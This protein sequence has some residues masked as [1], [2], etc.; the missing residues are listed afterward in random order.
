M[1]AE[2]SALELHRP[3]VSVRVKGQD[4]MPT[5]RGGTEKRRLTLTA[6]KRAWKSTDSGTVMAQAIG[7]KGK[8]KGLQESTPPHA[9]GDS[10]DRP[11]RNPPQPDQSKANVI[12]RA[13]EEDIVLGRCHPR[14]RLIEH[15]LCD[16][17]KTH[18]GDVRQALYELEKKGI[19]LRIPNRGAM[20][21]DLAP[22]EVRQIYA[23]REEL[24]IMAVRTIPFPVAQAD[25]DKLD[26]LQREHSAAVDAGD[27]LTVFY[28]NLGFHRTVFELCQNP[29]LS[30]TIDQLAQRVYGIRSYANAFPEA[31]ERVRRDHREII[32]AMRLGRRDELIALTHRHL[33]PSPDAYIR[34]YERR[35]GES[36]ES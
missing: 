27:M 16:R 26:A 13:L 11:Q 1:A 2:C 7:K 19:V 32:E 33:K 22:K 20:V 34:A 6:G 8:R 15:D 31:L 30:D 28:S 23:V 9:G 3:R 25:L 24:E 12:A 36:A 35:F 18:R 14:E 21:R 5:L 4:S 17:F 10:A 29:V